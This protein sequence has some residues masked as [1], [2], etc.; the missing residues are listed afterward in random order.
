[1]T[2]FFP[3][4]CHLVLEDGD[5]LILRFKSEVLAIAR[6]FDEVHQQSKGNLP[7]NQIILTS[8]KWTQ[9]VK[10]FVK[11]CM[12]I[13]GPTFIFANTLELIA[14]TGIQIGPS[15][16][17]S[18]EAKVK[19]VQEI[20]TDKRTGQR[21]MIFCEDSSS[22]KRLAAGLARLKISADIIDESESNI[23]NEEKRRFWQ[24][25]PAKPLIVSDGAQLERH[26]NVDAVVHFDIPSSSKA[27]FVDR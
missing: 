17:D 2:D 1:M 20:L 23:T 16:C 11:E 25:N 8:D 15:F 22:C 9:R 7:R 24:S 21:V 14:F 13:H 5:E 3:R 4:C 27:M 19:K 18:R 10:E 26:R 12:D 6:L